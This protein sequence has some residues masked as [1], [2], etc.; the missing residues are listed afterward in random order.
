MKGRKSGRKS[1]NMPDQCKKKKKRERERERWRLVW[2]KCSRCE[3]I[4][5]ES[6]AKLMKLELRTLPSK[7]PSKVPEGT[8]A[9]N[10]HAFVKSAREKY[11]I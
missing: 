9:M 4:A 7:I 1:K 6:N 8:P 11:L 5:G 3:P 2:L 10:S